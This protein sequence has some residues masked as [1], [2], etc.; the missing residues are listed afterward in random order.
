MH[1]RQRGGIGLDVEGRGEVDRVPSDAIDVVGFRLP[2]GR[3]PLERK[4]DVARDQY[5]DRLASSS[6]VREARLF[7]PMS[8]TFRRRRRIL[9]A[10][11][12]F[13]SDRRAR[14]RPSLQRDLRRP[15]RAELPRRRVAPAAAPHRGRRRRVP[16]W[17]RACGAVA[18]RTRHD[19]MDGQAAPALANEGPE[20][21]RARVGFR[22][23][24]PQ[25]EAGMRIEPPPS[26]RV[27]E[28]RDAGGHRGRGAPRRA[29]RR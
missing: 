2:L 4:R 13:G 20:G 18:H 24:S 6:H 14:Q 19:V 22:P 5:P 15:G 7:D 11:C 25:Q 27:R 16:R 17:R 10:F 9:K 29:L 28:R 8:E 23:N 21:V 1:A 26:L 12:A 3:T